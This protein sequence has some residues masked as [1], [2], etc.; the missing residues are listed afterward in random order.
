MASDCSSEIGRS[1]MKDLVGANGIRPV[2]QGFNR[3]I[4]LGRDHDWPI[5]RSIDRSLF[6][7]IAKWVNSLA[8]RVNA[9]DPYE[10]FHHSKTNLRSSIFWT[11]D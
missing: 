4:L 8:S 6:N 2:R 10:I 11:S 3:S 1:E 9:I 7:I 5:D